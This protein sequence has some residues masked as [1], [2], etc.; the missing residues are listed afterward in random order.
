MVE[1]EE[2]AKWSDDEGEIL[3]TSSSS[4]FD[5]AQA[6]D[7]CPEVICDRAEDS[8]LAGLAGFVHYC[9]PLQTPPVLSAAMVRSLL[10]VGQ[11]VRAQSLFEAVFVRSRKAQAMVVSGS[12]PVDFLSGVKTHRV[13]SVVLRR[14]LARY[15][16]LGGPELCHLLDNVLLEEFRQQKHCQDMVLGNELIQ[17]IT[18]YCRVSTRAVATVAESKKT[19]QLRMPDQPSPTLESPVP[20]PAV[21]SATEGDADLLRLRKVQH[22]GFLPLRE[23]LPTHPRAWFLECG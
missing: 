14:L 10:L 1:Q 3:V 9:D 4:R 22:N 2:G 18:V 12:I 15:E 19:V 5:S 11:A 13:A 21:P 16:S 7:D 17:E 23:E 6:E 8:T 20:E